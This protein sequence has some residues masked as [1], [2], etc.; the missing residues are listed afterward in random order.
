MVVD[1]EKVDEFSPDLHVVL[2]NRWFSSS[3]SARGLRDNCQLLAFPRFIHVVCVVNMGL[4]IDT[5]LAVPVGTPAL[6]A[7]RLA[8][9]FRLAE[10]STCASPAFSI[11]RVDGIE[12][13]SI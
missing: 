9:H 10:L 3:I 13:T 11:E 6:R 7:H 8:H 1:S 4:Y 2:L 12:E 5:L